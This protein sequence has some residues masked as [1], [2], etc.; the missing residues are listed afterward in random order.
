MSKPKVLITILLTLALTGCSLL[1]GGSQPTSTVAASPLPST[2]PAPADTATLAATD[3]EAPIPIAGTDTLAPPSATPGASASA[4]A[5]I[6]PTATISATATASATAPVNLTASVPQGGGT[7]KADFVADVTVPDGTTFKSGQAF[8]KTW[9]IKNSGTNPWTTAYALVYV[10]GDQ[11]GGPATVPLSATV[12]PGANAEISVNLTAPVKLGSATGFWMLRNA[13]GK[14]FGLSAD[15]NQPIYVKINVG[16]EAGPPPATAVPGALNVSAVALTVDQAA[17]TGTCP[18]TYVFN[19][20]LTSSGAGDIT[21]RLEAAS[22]KPGFVFNL[23]A[24]VTSTF[25]TAGPR[26]FS[27]S[28]QLSFTGSVGGQA[29]LHM[30]TPRDLSSAKVDFNLTCQP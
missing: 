7:D 24:V 10:R 11:M 23:P 21:Y 5:T 25:T 19:G 28:Y 12:A 16:A 18:R 6:S 8:V 26:T 27:V 3:T 20:T 22:D 4:T 29:W 9:Q 2:T 14:L 30:L 17:F 13:A 1:G 15:A